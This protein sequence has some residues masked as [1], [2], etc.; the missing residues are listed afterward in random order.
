MGKSKKMKILYDHQIFAIQKYGG[1]SR[2]FYELLSYYSKNPDVQ[3]ELSLLKTGNYYLRDSK[4]IDGSMFVDR[5]NNDENHSTPKIIGY[6]K[7][8]SFPGKAVLKKKVKRI[9]RPDDIA[10]VNENY[11]RAAIRSGRF[12]IFHPTY[13]DSYFLKQL[14]GR[15]FVLTVYDMIHELF[16]KQY[17][18][19]NNHII[20]NKR[21]LVKKAAKVIAISENTKK[22]LLQIYNVPAEKIEVVYLASTFKRILMDG[23]LPD[24]P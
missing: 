9:L 6:F 19:L 2:Y 1:I 21:I 16:S 4:L 13:Y 17:R 18:D 22:D 8:F 15:P 5:N 7:R 24:V 11:S 14:K 3:C 10:V 23:G 12:D 20:R